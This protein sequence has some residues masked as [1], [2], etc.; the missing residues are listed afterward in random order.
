MGNLR[1]CSLKFRGRRGGDFCADFARRRGSDASI[2]TD[3][4]SRNMPKSAE[5]KVIIISLINN[6]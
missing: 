3:E 6:N 4:F 5:A 1:A 2:V